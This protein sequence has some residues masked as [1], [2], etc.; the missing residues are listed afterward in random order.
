M[1]ARCTFRHNLFGF[2]LWG[3]QIRHSNHIIPSNDTKV[4][5]AARDFSD[6]THLEDS[7]S[8]PKYGK[9]R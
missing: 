6:D 8:F 3:D 5:E 4:D 1:I 9:R 2:Q 7:Y